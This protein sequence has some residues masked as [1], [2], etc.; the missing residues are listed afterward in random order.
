MIWQGKGFKFSFPS[1]KKKTL[2][3]GILNLT[4]DSFSGDGVVN[5]PPSALERAR[6]MEKEG[7]DLIDIGAE[8]T[9]PGAKNLSVKE[10]ISRL[11]PVLK[12]VR[13]Q[14]KIP[15][16]IDTQKSQVAEA[17]LG[18]GVNI[19]NDVSCLKRDEKL[20]ETA[21]SSGAGFILMHSRGTSQTM[22]GLNQYRSL[23]KDI[24]QEIKRALKLLKK[25]GV[26]Q[27][28]IAI[29]PGIGFAKIGPQNLELLRSI[30]DF[31]KLGYPICVGISRKSFIGDIVKE[32][33]MMRDFGTTALHSLLVERGVHILRVHSVRAVK[34]AVL[35][36]QALLQ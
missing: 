11:V 31:K 15:L 6:Q 5:S 27:K 8:S 32:P 4:P 12:K 10:E 9:R 2:I 16:S 36:T 25:A 21:A 28:A 19:I 7:A 14:V 34:Q 18:E 20:A 35:V 24:I 1:S 13:K 22:S 29:D 26:S 3:M 33:P 23:T 30:E 17:A